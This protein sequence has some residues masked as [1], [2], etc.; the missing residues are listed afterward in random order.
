MPHG[1]LL[2]STHKGN[3]CS[4]LNCPVDENDNFRITTEPANWLTA[5]LNASAY[6]SITAPLVNLMFYLTE[7]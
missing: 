3:D 2:K 5:K 1:E 6:L 4:L 7:L